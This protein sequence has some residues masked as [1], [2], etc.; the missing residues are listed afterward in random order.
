MS[1]RP[2][3]LCGQRFPGKPAS[4]Y[5]AW[6]VNGEDRVAWRQR[7]CQPCLSRHFAQI[8]RSSNSTSTDGL[9][10]PACGGSSENDL[11]AVFCVLYLPKQTEREYEL[12]TDAACAAKIRV[13]IWERGERLPDRSSPGR[14][15][16]PDAHS[17]WD[18]LDL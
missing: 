3:D 18:D 12:N 7:L 11:D 6:Y 2:C 8:F 14:G 5:W 17:P 4:L 15:P 13:N 16:S 1:P 10:C 9:T